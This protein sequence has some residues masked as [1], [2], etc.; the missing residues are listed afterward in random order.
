M[1][2][3]K[4]PRVVLIDDDEVFNTIMLRVAEQHGVEL[5]A[6]TSLVELGGV[7]MLGR[8]DVAIVDY[9]LG[10]LTGVEIGHYLSSLFKGLPMILISDGEP[11][12]R[13]SE[14]LPDSIVTFYSKRLGYKKIM[15]KAAGLA[16]KGRNR[17]AAVE[18][19]L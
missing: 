12:S 9:N 18:I 3:S 7:A 15:E 4:T 19:R 2:T 5:D 6:F 11:L 10:Y 1:E 16:H 17:V 13:L 14:A 8:Y